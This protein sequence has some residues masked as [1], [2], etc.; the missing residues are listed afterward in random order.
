MGSIIVHMI[1]KS[2]VVEKS[3]SDVKIELE[4]RKTSMGLNIV[5][6]ES[7]ALLQCDMYAK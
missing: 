6:D 1:L 7:H 2:N 5:E 3:I 4:W